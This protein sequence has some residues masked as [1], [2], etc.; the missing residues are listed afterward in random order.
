M[1]PSSEVS[2]VLYPSH[3][4]MRF[5]FL[6]FSKTQ[7]FGVLPFGAISRGISDLKRT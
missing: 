2:Q 6:F 7:Y 3:V 5:L 4:Y 1:S